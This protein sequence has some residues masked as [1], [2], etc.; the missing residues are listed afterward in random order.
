MKKR[1]NKTQQKKTSDR[2]KKK[3]PK[4]LITCQKRNMA[5]K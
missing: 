2:I 1:N 4:V 3:G 5:G